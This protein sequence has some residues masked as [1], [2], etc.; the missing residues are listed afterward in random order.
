MC[1]G[2]GVGEA[3]AGDCVAEIVGDDVPVNDDCGLSDSGAGVPLTDDEVTSTNSKRHEGT[4]DEN[5]YYHQKVYNVC[6]ETLAKV[7]CH[8]FQRVQG[9]KGSQRE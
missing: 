9:I 3:E 8:F 4:D 1:E 5:E 2:D 6:I 7:V